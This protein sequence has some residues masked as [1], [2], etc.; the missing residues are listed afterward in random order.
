MV[1]ERK[2]T[3]TGMSILVLAQMKKQIEERLTGKYL[4]YP[5][6][7]IEHSSILIVLHCKA[8]QADMIYNQLTEIAIEYNLHDNLFI[9]PH[10]FIF[11]NA[12]PEVLSFYDKQLSGND[13]LPVA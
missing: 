3:I 11:N 6:S 1:Q 7:G 10:T 9:T 8:E 2:I 5:A 12:K 13:P 4:C